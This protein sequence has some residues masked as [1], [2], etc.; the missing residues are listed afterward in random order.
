[1]DTKF[2]FSNLPKEL[3]NY[4]LSYTGKL[5]YHNGKYIGKINKDDIKYINLIN[6]PKPVK[7]SYNKYNLYLIN[8]SDSIGYILHYTFDSIKSLT[9][10]QLILKK[11]DS[12]KT[13]EWFIMP[14]IY[15]KWRRVASLPIL[16]LIQ[17]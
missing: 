17:I 13:I 7:I 5:Y 9:C 2:I 16:N 10:L 1:M 15:S 4:I 3:I 6:I 11:K 14:S 8:N 12:S